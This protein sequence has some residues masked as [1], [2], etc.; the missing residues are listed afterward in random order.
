M[1]LMVFSQASLYNYKIVY[2]GDNIGW[3]KLEKSTEGHKSDLSLLSEIKTRL[4]VPVNIYLKEQ[5]TFENGKLIFSSQLRKTN[6]KVKTD[7]QTKLVN[8]K[9]EMV[10]NGIRNTLS[11]PAINTNLLSLFFEEPV[12]ANLVYSEKQQRFLRIVKTNDGGY[13]L[14]FP[15]GNKNCFYYSKGICT[16]IKVEHNLYAVEVILTP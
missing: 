3:M 14:K 5:S 6:G 12:A 4:V 11:H 7:K 8:N 9:Y 1:P 13:Q 15:N 10:E 2:K 16:K